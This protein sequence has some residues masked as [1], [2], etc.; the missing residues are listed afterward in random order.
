MKKDTGIIAFCMFF[1]IYFTL[2]FVIKAQTQSETYRRLDSNYSR[3]KS[4]FD[5]EFG[6]NNLPGL[7]DTVSH[8]NRVFFKTKLPDWIINPPQSND[9]MVY[10]IGISEPEMRKDSA[11]RLAVL[12]AKAVMALMINSKIIGL[13][14]YYVS[15]KDTKSGD[16]FSSDYSEFNKITGVLHFNPKDFKIVEDTFSVNNEAIVLA[17]MHLGR[18]LS[19]DSTSVNCLCEVSGSHKK[20]NDKYFTTSRTE[21]RAGEKD[22]LKSSGNYFYYIMKKSNK[23]TLNLSYFSGVPIS[24]NTE[25]MTYYPSE[26]YPDSLDITNLSCTLQNGLWYAFSSDLLQALVLTL[27]ESN[28][29]QGSLDDKYPSGVQNINRIFSQ[30]EISIRLKGLRVQNNKLFASLKISTTK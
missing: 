9:S 13:A 27:Q 11:F 7:N 10:A 23:Q 25:L 28:V 19:N 16:I 24:C 4:E 2:P 21:I 15:E 22:S 1:V 5:K 12:R 3:F 29:K 6:L 30:K 14:D 17:S 26:K 8:I 20:K 18:K